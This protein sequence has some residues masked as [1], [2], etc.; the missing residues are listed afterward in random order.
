MSLRV[1]EYTIKEFTKKTLADFEKLFDT[2]PAAGAYP[3]WCLYNHETCSLP[4]S[5]VADHAKNRRQRKALVENGRSHG[6][7]V[8]AEGH[9]WDGVSTGRKTSFHEST[10]I[11]G[12]EKSPP[13]NRRGSGESVASW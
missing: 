1:A 11:P 5:G 6:I 13:P 10:P 4:G 2:H 7:V 12:I 3:C 9:R 8:Y